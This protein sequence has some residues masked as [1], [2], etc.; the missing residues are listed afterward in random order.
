LKALLTSDDLRNVFSQKA[1]DYVS[2]NL[3]PE[4]LYEPFLSLLQERKAAMLSA[5]LEKER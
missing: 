1:R 2:R 4:S 3:T 5:A